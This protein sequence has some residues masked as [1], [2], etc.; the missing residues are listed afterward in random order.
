M[1]SLIEKPT[2]CAACKLLASPDMQPCLACWCRAGRQSVAVFAAALA[3]LAE[4]YRLAPAW[5][6]E[7]AAGEGPPDDTLSNEA[8]RFLENAKGLSNKLAEYVGLEADELP[9]DVATLDRISR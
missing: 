1:P 7:L 6:A 2:L 8:F 5:L 4:V 9:V 3:H